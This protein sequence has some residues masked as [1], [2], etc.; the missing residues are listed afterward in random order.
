MGPQAVRVLH[1]CA[2]NLYGGVERIVA[3]CAIDRA[4]CQTMTPAFA[5]AFE[6]RLAGEI[7]GA[8]A[9]MTTIGAAR[10]SRPWTILQARRRLDRLLRRDP[11]DAVVCHSSWAFGLTAPVV[12]KAGCRLVLWLHDRV[13]GATWPERWAGRTRPDVI[14]ANSRFTAASV[15][16]LYPQSTPVVVYAPVRTEPDDGARAALRSSLGVADGTPV[17]LMASRFEPWKGHRELIDALAQV[18]EPWQLWIAGGAQRVGEQRLERDIRARA[19]ASGAAPRIRFLG[20]R[21]DVGACMR[22]ADIHCQPNSGPEPFGLAFVEAL[23]AG[24][25]VVTTAIGGA[26]EIVTPDCGVLVPPA[27]SDA[28]TAALRGLI[29]D[30]QARLRLGAGGPARAAALCDPA[31]QLSA[32]AGLLGGMPAVAA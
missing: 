9:V 27:D 32:L 15:P 11:V 28:L 7:A 10:A 31:R 29:V 2:G 23:Y 3:E 26:L 21:R 24:L 22:A 1:V 6:G 12:R 13:S 16:A 5:I 30:R 18:S 17:V 20:E 14:V 4:L 19:A 25:P 8:G